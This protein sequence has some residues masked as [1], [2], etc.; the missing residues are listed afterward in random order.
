[1]R[2][3]NFLVIVAV[4]FGLFLSGCATTSQN[5]NSERKYM[6][7]SKEYR[8]LL[9][10]IHL[11]SVGVR[12]QKH[13]Q[14][15]NHALMNSLGFMYAARQSRKQN[16]IGATA[17]NY[18]MA[19]QSSNLLLNLLQLHFKN[20]GSYKSYLDSTH[21]VI[22][23]VGESC[24]GSAMYEHKTERQIR[25]YTKD[26][27]NIF[28]ASYYMHA[29]TLSLF[30]LQKKLQKN[31]L[32]AKSMQARFTGRG[33]TYM[34]NIVKYSAHQL[35]RKIYVLKIMIGMRYVSQVKYQKAYKVFK[36][37]CFNRAYLYGKYPSE[38]I[39]DACTNE[40]LL[41][42]YLN[43]PSNKTSRSEQA[44]PK[45]KEQNIRDMLSG[46]VTK[47]IDQKEKK[48]KKL[49]SKL[50]DKTDELLEKLEKKQK[51]PGQ[52]KPQERKK[53]MDPFNP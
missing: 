47:Y 24:M 41:H 53:I 23:M 3:K 28:T 9:H 22:N 45:V 37:S 31:K 10:S 50:T 40:K 49:P 5:T 36:G 8:K 33:P 26:L 52:E 18:A 4:F 27:L 7:G 44:K 38:M 2:K 29:R 32:K 6:I 19:C 1:M 34:L 30:D 17:Y 51:K 21:F 20:F 43:H 16:N 14:T 46:M 42:R 39:D 15:I 11:A 48:G 25:F 12:S 13:L 35:A